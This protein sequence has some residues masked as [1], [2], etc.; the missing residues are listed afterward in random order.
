M[1][2]FSLRQSG[3]SHRARCCIGRK[4]SFGGDMWKLA[5]GVKR[6]QTRNGWSRIDQDFFTAVFLKRFHSLHPCCVVWVY[7]DVARTCALSLLI[8]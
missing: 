6:E 8:P 5:A 4:G 2:F 7:V 3:T 1:R